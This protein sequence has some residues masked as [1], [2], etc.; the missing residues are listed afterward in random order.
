MTS[1]AA[2]RAHR[3][4]VAVPAPRRA[5]RRAA[6]DRRA[7]ITSATRRTS[8]AWRPSHNTPQR[9]SN[10]S[11]RETSDPP[12]SSPA[13]FLTSSAKK[14]APSA[15]AT[16]PHEAAA[17][18]ARCCRRARC[19][20][21]RGPSGR[22]ADAGGLD[23]PQPHDHPAD[24]ERQRA[25]AQPA[26]RDVLGGD[27]R[28]SVADRGARWVGALAHAEHDRPAGDVAVGVGE[29]PPA[30]DVDAVREVIG[31]VGD[32]RR[33][34][35]GID[36]HRVDGDLPAVDV[37]HLE[38][39]ELGRDGLAEPQA[40]LCRGLM[41]DGVRGRVGADQRRVRTRRRR[42]RQPGG[43]RDRGRDEEAPDPAPAS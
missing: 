1:A 28:R 8:N 39:G 19:G 24:E 37:G 9:V 16:I 7:R 42:G 40:D 27:E 10:R 15:K 12:A 20:L 23:Q 36:P 18:S 26:Q 4:V 2:P 14:P 11:D 43:E 34:V 21:D 6:A 17:D 25:E 33:G 30:H 31:Q 22:P 38:G 5:P 13:T 35:P 3:T 32:E 41:E 29:K